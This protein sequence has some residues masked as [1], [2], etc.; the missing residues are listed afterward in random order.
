[1]SYDAKAQ[2]IFAISDMEDQVIAT[3]ET[4]ISAFSTTTLTARYTGHVDPYATPVVTVMSRRLRHLQGG[5]AL[6][7]FN[8]IGICRIAV[9]NTA[10]YSV[11]IGRHEFIGGLDQWHNVDEPRLLDTD[12]VTKF[13]HNWKL[14]LTNICSIPVT[15]PSFSLIKKL[16]TMP[17]STCLISLKNNA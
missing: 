17:T 9:T 10:L 12:V 13:I 4:T 1:M 14:K 3:G 16:K 2:Q 8:D 15:Q 5:P 11:T 7:K 6:V